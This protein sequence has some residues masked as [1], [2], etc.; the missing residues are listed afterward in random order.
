MSASQLSSAMRVTAERRGSSLFA[1]SNILPSVPRRLSVCVCMSRSHNGSTP[2]LALTRFGLSCIFN[3][4]DAQLSVALFRGT[5]L[6]SVTVPHPLVS[7]NNGVYWQHTW[8]AKCSANSRGVMGVE[9]GGGYVYLFRCDAA[10]VR[11]SVVQPQEEMW[12]V[13]G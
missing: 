10:W 5:L 1:S 2:P 7:R 6:K 3:P 8:L 13:D 11:F 4:S 9:G 12:Q